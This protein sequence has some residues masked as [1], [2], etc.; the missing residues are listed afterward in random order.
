MECVI[1]EPVI[2]EPNLMDHEGDQEGYWLEDN[3]RCYICLKEEGSIESEKFYNPGCGCKGS[4]KIHKACMR[5]TMMSRGSCECPVCKRTMIDYCDWSGRR[6]VYEIVRDGVVGK[7]TVR[8]NG[9]QEGVYEEYDI[10][11]KT[12]LCHGE[13]HNGLMHG[14]WNWWRVGESLRMQGPYIAGKRY[15]AWYEFAED[16]LEGYTEVIY[17]YDDLIE[18]SRYNYRQEKVD[19]EY[20]GM[21]SM[22][23]LGAELSAEYLY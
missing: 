9:I 7:Y 23:R 19:Y 20:Y 11:S 2:T 3:D 1:T 18:Y 6:I 16:P 13:Y 14:E 21:E 17:Y 4:L 5:D 8:E 10:E 15:G 12:M 22:K